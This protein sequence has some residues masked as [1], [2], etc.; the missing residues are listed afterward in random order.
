MAQWIW[1]YGDFEIY[2]TLQLHARRQ[3][4][5]ADYPRRLHSLLSVHGRQS[6]DLPLRL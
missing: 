5:G 4:Y 3:E 2:H 6:G 1:Y